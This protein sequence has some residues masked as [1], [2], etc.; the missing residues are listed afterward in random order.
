MIIVGA[1][2][3]GLVAALELAA[4]GI[5][6]LVLE[7]AT[8]VGGKMRQVSVGGAAMDAGPTVF[9][10]RW[11]FEELFDAVGA[12]LT[13]HL[14]LQPASILARHA[15]S[16][17]ERLDLF[18]DVKRSAEAIGDFA[19][20]NACRGYL[21]FCARAREMYRALEHPFLRSA[22]PN[23]LTLAQRM[24]LRG[25]PDLMRISPFARMWP[26]LGRHFA[27][28]RLRQLFGRYANYCGV[29]PFEA[30]ATLM[31]VAHVEQDGV[32]L[33]EGGMH[34]VAQVLAANALERGA[35]IRLES[36][37]S[38]ILT[39][40]GRA[41]GVRLASGEELSAAAVVFNG[42]VAALGAGLLGEAV[43]PSAARVAA[44][45]RSFSALT[46]NLLASTQGFPLSRHTVFF[47]S[48]YAAEFQDIG[49]GRLAA[50]PTVYVCAQDR[51]DADDGRT[52]AERL[53]VVVN[54]P[55]TGD[56]QPATLD[57]LQQCEAEAFGLMARCGLSVERAPKNTVMTTPQDFDRCFPA[58]G[59]AL[60]GPAL[61]GWLASF[62]R[63]GARSSL[64]GLYLAGG[65]VHPGPGVPMAALSGRQAA[66]SV[67]ADRVRAPAAGRPAT[68]PAHPGAAPSST[69]SP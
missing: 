14:Q 1:G 12:R 16:A 56:T 23:P 25:L 52:G 37:V 22:R 3:G 24:G 65:S 63:P 5:E 59:G 36:P 34:R 31:L 47:S 10:M 19:G 42:D 20:A 39:R 7:A 69:S 64:P 61:R 67:M 18:A 26:E 46:W 66:A 35:T 21:D 44:A 9:T 68:A 49:R 48:D 41:C 4:R 53:L 28:P 29:S 33:V 2:V 6:V 51:S 15:W 17:Q 27:D 54:A 30:S 58:T 60:Y 50:S 43:R 11:V 8:Q 32:W 55:A 57:E 38:A 62:S 13:D 45:E 40:D